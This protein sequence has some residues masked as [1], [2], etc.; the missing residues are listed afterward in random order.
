MSADKVFSRSLS[1]L[2]ADK[3]FS[4]SQSFIF[5]GKT[6]WKPDPYDAAFESEINENYG[7]DRIKAAAM[8]VVKESDKFH[9]IH[10]GS[11]LVMLNHQIRVRDLEQYPTAA[12]IGGSLNAYR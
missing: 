11:N 6:K 9:I 5:P 8:A 1:F 10:D 3:E 7:K 12:D 4:S 2:L